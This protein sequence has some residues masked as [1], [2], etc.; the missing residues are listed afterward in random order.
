MISIIYFLILTNKCNLR[1]KYC[2]EKAFDDCDVE[3]PEDIE[4]LDNKVEYNT[5]HLKALIKNDKNPYFIFYGGEPTLR[6]DLIRK[7]IGSL[8]KKTKYIIQTN[9]LLIRYLE[10]KYLDR[11]ESIFISIDGSKKIT[12]KYRG[13]DTYDK[14]V[15]NIKSIKKAGYKKEITAR[16][17]ILEQNIYKEVKHLLKTNLFS[18]IHWQIDANFWFNDYKKRNFKEWLENNYKPNLKKLVEFWFNDMKKGNVLKLYPFIGIMHNILGK[19]K[20]KLMCGAGYGNYTIQTNGKIIPCPI[21]AGMKNYY[22]GDIKI[23][24]KIQK[25]IH[26]IPKECKICDYLN[27]CGSRCLYSNIIQPWP[28]NQRKYICEATKYLIDLLLAKEE[29]IKKLIKL[30]IIYKRDFDY[31]KYNGA[32]IIP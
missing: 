26:I 10:C 21:M 14:I 12:D 20:T 16:M 3:F 5:K 1:C 8:P 13:K 18:A 9:G 4:E 30:N 22:L 11:V 28:K 17:V 31:L 2:F 15:D 32:E 25:E 24:P 7:I 27:L 6:M 23:N 19:K 29:D